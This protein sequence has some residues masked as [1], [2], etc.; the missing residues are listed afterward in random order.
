MY[1]SHIY[2]YIYR[3]RERDCL[4]HREGGDVVG[5]GD[6]QLGLV[7]PG[8]RGLRAL[9]RRLADPAL[10]GDLRLQGRERLP[11]ALW[12]RLAAVFPSPG[13]ARE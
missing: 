9:Q 6:L 8:L 11:E 10:R 13:H 2:I 12:R 7:A 3:E 4:L 1:T 5:P